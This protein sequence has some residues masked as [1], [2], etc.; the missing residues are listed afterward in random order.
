MR[1]IDNPRRVMRVRDAAAYLGISTRQ[2][3]TLVQNREL[4]VVR[5]FQN[6]HSPWT[7]D[8]RDLDLL[9]ERRKELL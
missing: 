8:Q 1:K 3:R 7:L 6:D 9:I 5:L 2:V 4:P